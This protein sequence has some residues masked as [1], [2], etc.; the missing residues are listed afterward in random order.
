MI[1]FRQPRLLAIDDD[2]SSAELI[3][4][5]AERCRYEAF[6]TSDSRG[7]L[8]L[9]SALAPDVL[10]IDIRMPNLDANDLLILLANAKYAGKILIISGQE[11]EILEETRVKAISLGL[12]APFALQKP[13][14]IAQLRM[15]L[16]SEE[17]SA[18]A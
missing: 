11:P 7:V 1:G 17:M 14:E 6:A 3:V 9:A 12:N 10:S 4:R 18:A 13:I 5:V 16:L 8:N 15:T 2:V